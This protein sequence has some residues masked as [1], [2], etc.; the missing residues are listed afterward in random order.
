MEDSTMKRSFILVLIVVVAALLA[1]PAWNFQEKKPI[2]AY[3]IKVV[4]D[5]ERRSGKTEGWSKALALT[6]LK[7]GYEVRTQEQSL[8]LIKFADDSKVT[9][10]PK[11][12][13][14]I[15]GEVQGGK[16]LNRDIYIERG[17]TLFDIK[18]Q[19]EEQ[20]R[21]TSPISVAS[22]RGT[23]GGT[24]FDAGSEFADITIITGVAD[25]A[26][27]RSGCQV[28]VGAGMTG[29]IDSTGACRS[30][31][32]TTGQLHNNDPLSGSGIDST[33]G[34]GGGVDS[35]RQGGTQPPQPTTV[36]KFTL[37]TPG[38]SLESGKGAQI[39]VA[40]TNAP[41]EITQATMFYRVQGE[42]SYRQIT[43]TQSSGNVTGNVPAADVR[44]GATRTFEYYFSMVGANGTTY[45]FPESDP[46]ATPYT[47]PI[48]PRVVYL[49]IPITTP[50]GEDRF[51]QISYEE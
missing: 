21:F 4:K 32:A 11:S 42:A 48:R 27:S 7:A 41:T 14:T 3:I 49:K 1:A 5:V 13:L 25:F 45:T 33:G 46:E 31:S 50:S 12:I 9:V 24:G 30:D 22:I 16:I 20:F 47:L 35:T 23:L 44:A 43:M 51:L 26:S 6:E 18:K 39:R 28:Q 8:A 15:Q 29:T 38:G 17:R 2:A 36:A 19:K 37:S 40:L 10:R 34:G